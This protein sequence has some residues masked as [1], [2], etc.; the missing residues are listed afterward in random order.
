MRTPQRVAEFIF[1]SKIDLFRLNAAT[2]L[3]MAETLT[4]INNPNKLTR[5]IINQLLDSVGR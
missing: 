3:V 2:Q 5:D 4:L 1:N